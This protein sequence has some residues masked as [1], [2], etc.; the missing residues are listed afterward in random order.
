MNDILECLLNKE[1][2]FLRLSELNNNHPANIYIYLLFFFFFEN[3]KKFNAD[4]Y[5]IYILS[6]K[7]SSNQSF[8]YF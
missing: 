4:S 6:V 3:E 5:K 7:Y 1:N 2:I 8:K